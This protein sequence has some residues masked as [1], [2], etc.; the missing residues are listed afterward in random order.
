MREL[1]VCN[2]SQAR[3]LNIWLIFGEFP[4]LVAHLTSEKAM[5]I[6][7]V[8]GSHRFHLFLL[9]LGSLCWSR[10]VVHL[11]PSNFCQPLFHR[12]D[13]M[14]IQHV[15]Q[16]PSSKKIGRV[17]EVPLVKIKT[18]NPEAP[19]KVKLITTAPMFIFFCQWMCGISSHILSQPPQSTW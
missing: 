2:S 9:L 17:S 13:N 15:S 7:A 14:K 12:G 6:R 16:Q 10:P 5:D 11:G 3:L 4:A 8:D 1:C 19:K 18:G